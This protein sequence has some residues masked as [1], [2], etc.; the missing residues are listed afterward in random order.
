MQY[1]RYANNADDY[2]TPDEVLNIILDR[3]STDR[4]IYEPFFCTC[5]SGKHMAA[6]GYAVIH[7]QAD[8]YTDAP[9]PYDVIVSNPPYSDRVRVFR[10]LHE[11]GKP[12][13]M[14]V[15]LATLENKYFTSLFADGTRLGVILP[16]RRV[17]FLKNGQ[18]TKKCSFPTAWLCWDM[19]VIGLTFA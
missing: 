18:K 3:I 11:I 7:R 10:K 19:G 2:E 1:S 8:F 12:W 4:V 9:P 17:E 13:A 15:P 6:R 14:L 5:R 16:K